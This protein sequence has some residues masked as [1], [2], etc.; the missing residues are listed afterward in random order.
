MKISYRYIAL[1]LRKL[2]IWKKHKNQKI[3]IETYDLRSIFQG[4][5]N[6]VDMTGLQLKILFFC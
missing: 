4:K 5:K 2:K 1:S 6:P 3:L